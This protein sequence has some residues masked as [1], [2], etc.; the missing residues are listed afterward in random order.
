M[1]ILAATFDFRDWLVVGV[2]L[3]AVI[4]LGAIFGR[5]Q[6]R[7]DEFFLGAR[8]MP[9]LAVAIS[10]LATSQSAATFLGVPERSYVG[11]LTYVSSP[12]A[13]LLAAVVV[14]FVFL[15][16]F[17]HHK[18]TSIYELLG[19]EFGP[20]SQRAASGMFMVGRI[21]ASGARLFIAAIPLAVIAFGDT[22][23]LSLLGAIAIVA[24]AATLYTLLGGIRAVIWTDVLQAVVAIGAVGIA[25]WLVWRQ[26]P[27]DAGELLGILRATDGTNKLTFVDTSFDVGDPM[28]LAREFNLWAVLLGLSL[29]NLAALGTD[30]DLTQR[31]LT[32]RS[33]TRGSWSVI[34]S[35]LLAW[36]V[37]ALFMLLGLLLYV[38]YQ[39]PDIMDAAAPGYQVDD[40]R[41]VFVDFILNETPP[42]VRGL[43][44]AGI[45]AAAMSSLDSALNA[46]ASTTVGDFYRPRL[47]RRSDIVDEQAQMRRELIVSRVSVLGWAIAIGGFACFCVWWH[48]YSEKPLVDFALGVMVFAYSGLLGVFLTALLTRRGN[49]TSVVCAL[50]A[51]F[52]AV[53][54]LQ[55]YS[56]ASGW[57][58]LLATSLSFA[59]CCAGRRG[60]AI[61]VRRS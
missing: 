41:R 3:L 18:V 38:Y 33:T 35:Q 51:G 13:G 23:P 59:V 45:F 42:G 53:L 37:V 2:Y 14:A 30:Q 19:H 32:C 11:D 49:S 48:D 52:I 9:L 47:R 28:M 26:I 29:L 1:T 31:M 27:V 44:I 16:A 39:R 22:E 34:L 7:R 61:L 40:S 17:Y 15:P 24:A 43:M 56:L 6:G 21:L 58:M 57:R 54:V 50:L 46:L 4:G 8:Q 20:V 5:R 25:I 55:Q 12:L 36:P 60:T 10:V